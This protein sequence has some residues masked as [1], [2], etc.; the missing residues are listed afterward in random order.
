MIGPVPAVRPAVATPSGPV[1]SRGPTEL[2]STARQR[3]A[4]PLFRSRLTELGPTLL[5]PQIRLPLYADICRISDIV[6]EI[7]TIYARQRHSRASMGEPMARWRRPGSSRLG[8][9]VLILVE[10]AAIGWLISSLIHLQWQDALIALSVSIAL[11]CWVLAVEAPTLCGVETI[12]K[13]QCQNRTTGLLLGCHAPGH[14]W[15]KFFARFGWRR[16]SLPSADQ[17]NSADNTGTSTA[18]P[19]LVKIAEDGKSVVV[20][21]AT[22]VSTATAVISTVL[23]VIKPG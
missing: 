14:A 17:G 5:Y 1:T 10:L 19:V 8:A 12:R 6:R 11:P 4:V 20:F 15:A 16:I 13:T 3:L 22:M 21:W 2:A 18:E 23:A 7:V 9:G